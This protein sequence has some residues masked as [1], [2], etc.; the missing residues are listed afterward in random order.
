MKILSRETTINLKNK[1]MKKKKN[2][3]QYHENYA[4]K[5]EARKQ[6]VPKSYQVG[7]QRPIPTS[8]FLQRNPKFFYGYFFSCGNFGHKVV[9]CRTFRHNMNIRIGFNKP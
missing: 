5:Y 6:Q 3:E 9:S 1:N 8:K 2:S 4:D 7:R